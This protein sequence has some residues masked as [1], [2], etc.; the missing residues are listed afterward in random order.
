MSTP[1]FVEDQLCSKE[2]IKSVITQRAY[3]I[4]RETIYITDRRVLVHRSR[5]GVNS[6]QDYTYDKVSSI[7]AEN[8]RPIEC[9]AA[10]LF[11]VVAIVFFL[12]KIDLT[13]Y[14]PTDY[15]TNLY[16]SVLASIISAGV[17]VFYVYR[18]YG[19][20]KTIAAAVVLFGF[21]VCEWYFF[22]YLVPP[23]KQGVLNFVASASYTAPYYYFLKPIVDS[24]SSIY[25]TQL[26]ILVSTIYGIIALV[27]FIARI[28]L[29][30][31]IMEQAWQT[32]TIRPYDPEIVKIIRQNM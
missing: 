8:T 30:L 15:P 2:K 25:P 10:F 4:L 22:N 26:A 32:V 18:S 28:S 31:L 5:F 27:C 3:F 9:L 7:Y 21:L 19:G 13:F 14:F 24:V 1:K 11:S 29:I 23:L 17:L 16:F 6:I 12:G 20:M